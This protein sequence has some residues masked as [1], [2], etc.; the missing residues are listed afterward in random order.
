MYLLGLLALITPS[1]GFSLVG[2]RPEFLFGT[3]VTRTGPNDS[4]TRLNYRN[5]HE[6]E[7]TD[8][9]DLLRTRPQSSNTRKQQRKPFIQASVSS[10]SPE[11]YY[12][13]ETT[14][15]EVDEYLEFLDRRYNRMHKSDNNARTTHYSKKQFPVLTWLFHENSG[16][17]ANNEDENHDNALY[18]LGVAGLASERLL[19]KHGVALHKHSIVHPAAIANNNENGV[20]VEVEHSNSHRMPLPL[21]NKI[22]AA[23]TATW[24]YHTHRQVMVR[25]RL[26]FRALSRKTRQ[27]AASALASLPESTAALVKALWKA[28]G[29]KHSIKLAAATLCFLLLYIAKPLVK[30]VLSTS[31]SA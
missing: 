2:N 29:G 3:G 21:L 26:L 15:K 17:I 10:S 8:S 23:F 16:S 4:L 31:T 24:I 22:V 19:Q 25:Q 11:N 27:V 1:L 5:S 13:D 12:S 6:N 9:K 20:V 30:G 14:R 7:R 18:A 28:G